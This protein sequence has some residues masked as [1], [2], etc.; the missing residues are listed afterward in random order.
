MRL[1]QLRS[2]HAVAQH[3]GFTAAA[4]A[5]HISQPTVNTQVGALEANYGV[6]LFLSRGRSVVLTDVGR[7][8]SPWRSGYSRKRKKR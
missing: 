8:S 1:T 4:R 2:F 6:E 7:N 5:L 3:G